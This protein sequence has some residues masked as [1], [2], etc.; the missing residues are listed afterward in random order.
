MQRRYTTSSISS[1]AIRHLHN[2]K[3]IIFKAFAYNEKDRNL[4][5]YRLY[6]R[7]LVCYGPQI[8]QT[9]NQNTT[10]FVYLH[11]VHIAIN[12]YMFRPLY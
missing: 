6:T 2:A 1:L 3:T 12:N 10:I 5:R 7:T 4:S 8:W 11:I 9:Y